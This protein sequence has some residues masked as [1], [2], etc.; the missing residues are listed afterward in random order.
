MKTTMNLPDSLFAEV[1][2][3]ASAENRT[4]TSFVEQALRVALESGSAGRPV[5]PLPTWRGGSSGGHLVDLDD[6]DA[7]WRVLD[8]PA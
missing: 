5:H 4:V 3:R 8:E 6:R 2:R 1:K 7:V